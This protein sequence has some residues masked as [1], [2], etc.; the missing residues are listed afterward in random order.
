MFKLDMFAFR[1]LTSLNNAVAIRK[2]VQQHEEFLHLQNK[3][4]F[5]NKTL[6]LT[7]INFYKIGVEYASVRIYANRLIIKLN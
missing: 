2:A 1:F 5:V 6:L 7:T 4:H 3:Q